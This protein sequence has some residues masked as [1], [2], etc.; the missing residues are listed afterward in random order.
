LFETGQSNG[1]SHVPLRTRWESVLFDGLYDQAAPA[2]RVKY[3]TLNLTLDP[4]GNQLCDNYGSSMLVLRD[5]VRARTT[6]TAHDSGDFPAKTPPGTLQD[7]AHVLFERTERD[8][9]ILMRLALGHKEHL[10]STLLGGYVECQFHGDIRLD[11]DVTSIVVSHKKLHLADRL[12][13]F[14]DR[15][16]FA[17]SILSADHD[18]HRPLCRAS[19]PTK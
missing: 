10:S 4:L 15:N 6:W 8:L 17:L 3:G 18:S 16:N 5:H 13:R 1:N 19:I 12:G 11:R 7:C 9:G 14:A 2:E